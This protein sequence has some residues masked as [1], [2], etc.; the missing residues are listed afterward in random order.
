MLASVAAGHVRAG[1]WTLAVTPVLAAVVLMV[2]FGL[3]G[4][5]AA[6][7]RPATNPAVAVPGL[8]SAPD[9][10]SGWT[11]TP[12]GAIGVEPAGC[13]RPRAALIA[14]SPRSLVGVLLTAPAGL[15]QVDEVAARYSTGGAAGAAFDSVAQMLDACSTVS[16]MRIASTGGRT[17]AA[18]LFTDGAG[19][20]F[21]VAQKGSGVVLLVYG[22]AGAPDT[23]AV[24]RLSDRAVQRLGP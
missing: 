14:S 16:R 11:A 23:S 8:L 10:G 18:Q 17:A 7:S 1:R 13:L 12:A 21:L 22:S 3:A 9:A 20:D 19:V 4:G 15:P 2:V 5:G 24:T 6:A